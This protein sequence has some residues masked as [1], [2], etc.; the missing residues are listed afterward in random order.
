MLCSNPVCSFVTS[1]PMGK[2]HVSSAHRKK[3]IW[4][5]NSKVAVGEQC[6]GINSLEQQDTLKLYRVKNLSMLQRSM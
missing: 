4:D 1:V 6:S 2:R 3:R 5:V